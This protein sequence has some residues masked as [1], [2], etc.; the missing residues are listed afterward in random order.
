MFLYCST[1]K[2]QQS[3]GHIIIEKYPFQCKIKQMLLTCLPYHFIFLKDIFH[4]S[5]V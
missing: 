4:P 3:Q 2:I 5:I 1:R